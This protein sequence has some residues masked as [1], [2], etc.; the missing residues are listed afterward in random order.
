MYTAGGIGLIV[1]GAILTFSGIWGA[2]FYQTQFDNNQCGNIIG[3]ATEGLQQ[4][5]GSNQMQQQCQ[6]MQSLHDGSTFVMYIGIFMVIG[7]IVLLA[8]R[9]KKHRQ[10]SYQG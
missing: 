5:F 9:G 8:V 4:L 7:G 2:S 10:Y 6:S 1:I 3:Q